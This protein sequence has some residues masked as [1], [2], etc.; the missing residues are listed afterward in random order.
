MRPEQ[1]PN[2]MPFQNLNRIRKKDEISKIAREL[3]E[4]VKLPQLKELVSEI[5]L[6]EYMRPHKVTCILRTGHED[7]RIDERE[8]E[9]EVDDI[10][11]L[12]L[13]REGFKEYTRVGKDF[14]YGPGPLCNEKEVRIS[15]NDYHRIIK[16]HNITMKDVQDLRS[17]LES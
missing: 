12:I 6:I 5:V 3:E 4:I 11:R 16:T 14:A 8:E 9:A 2:K 7:G 1:E 10:Y 15:K 17:K 13:N